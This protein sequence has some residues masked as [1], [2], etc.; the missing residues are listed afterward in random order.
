MK[1]TLTRSGTT[2]DANDLGPLLG[3]DP[4]QVPAKMRAGE[5][6]SLSEEGIDEDAGKTRLTFWY[7]RKRVRVT[8]DSRGEVIQTSKATAI[9]GK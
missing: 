9:R 8:C 1:V 4:S 7:N 2:I 5:I 6:T 3:L